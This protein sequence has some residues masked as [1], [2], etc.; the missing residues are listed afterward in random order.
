MAPT[1]S[2]TSTLATKL[3]RHPPPTNT[4]YL[5]EAEKPSLDDDL[6][7][8]SDALPRESDHVFHPQLRT[9]PEAERAVIRK[10]DWR[11]C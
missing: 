8:A 1:Q 10:L 6:E 9:N 4:A 3:E 11:V 7:K 2:N 5:T